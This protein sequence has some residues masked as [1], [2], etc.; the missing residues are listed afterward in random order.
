MRNVKEEEAVRFFT[1]FLQE[2]RSGLALLDADHSFVNSSFGK[3]FGIDLKAGDR[4]RVDGLR[5][6]ELA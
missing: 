3:H 2:A 1:D 6:C 4:E 5:A